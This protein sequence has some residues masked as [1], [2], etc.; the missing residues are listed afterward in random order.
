LG[1]SLQHYEVTAFY[2]PMQTRVVVRAINGMPAAC[3]MEAY[4]SMD[5]GQTATIELPYSNG[6]WQEVMVQ[7]DLREFQMEARPVQPWYG[8]TF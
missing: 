6:Q 3:F 2:I 7:Y 5:V 1:G 8:A 4:H